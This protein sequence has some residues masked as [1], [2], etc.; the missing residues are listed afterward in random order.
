M[1]FTTWT[2]EEKKFAQ[3]KREGKIRQTNTSESSSS[4]SDY[5]SVEDGIDKTPLM[6]MTYSNTDDLEWDLETKKLKEYTN[7]CALL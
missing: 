3:E 4:D 7:G 2:E 6:K 1:M 5:G